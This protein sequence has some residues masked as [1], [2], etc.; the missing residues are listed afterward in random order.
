MLALALLLIGL[1]AMRWPAFGPLGIDTHWLI[2]P[3]AAWLV[4]RFGRSA[5]FAVIAIVLCCVFFQLS[6]GVVVGGRVDI[7]IVALICVE[8]ARRGIE[9]GQIALLPPPPRGWMVAPL[10]LPAFFSMTPPLG[11]ELNIT[12]A[13]YVLSLLLSLLFVAA[14]RGA[15]WQGY[16]ISASLAVALGATLAIIAHGRAQSATWSIGYSF[17][18]P[19]LWLPA[20]A[21]WSAGDAVRRASLGMVPRLFWAHPLLAALAILALSIDPDQ[22][23]LPLALRPGWGQLRWLVFVGETAALPLA[24]F[25]AGA[26]VGIRGAWGVAVMALVPALAAIAA[27]WASDGQL[28]VRIDNV[29]AAPIALAWGWLGARLAGRAMNTPSLRIAALVLVVGVLV[30]GLLMDRDA[31]LQLA[32]SLAA[33]IATAVTG[34]LAIRLSRRIGVTGDGWVPVLLLPLYV[35]GLVSF[36]PSVAELARDG[37]VRIFEQLGSSASDKLLVHLLMFGLSTFAAALLLREILRG[38]AWLPKVIREIGILV[39]AATQALR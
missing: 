29:F 16:A 23:G 14:L 32:L 4:L 26:L 31:A 34:A 10:L 6:L 19:Y 22:F 12:L 21:A 33:S 28:R 17:M 15:P 36:G 18:Q 30:L 3:I 25:V 39:R 24:S 2:P 38:L 35:V 9:L 5:R 37:G 13:W 7:A 1:A 8:V 20:A 27:Y 11:D